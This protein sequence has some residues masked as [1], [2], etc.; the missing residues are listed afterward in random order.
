MLQ[1]IS[2][3]TAYVLDL[4]ELTDMILTDVTSTLHRVNAPHFLSARKKALNLF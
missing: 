3:S 4:S 2:R 1:R